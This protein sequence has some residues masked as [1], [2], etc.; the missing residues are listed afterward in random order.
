MALDPEYKHL[1]ARP[2][3]NYRQLFV[4]GRRIRAGVIYRRTINVEHLTPQEVAADF[5][6][7]LIAVLERSGVVSFRELDH[8]TD[9]ID[10]RARQH[11]GDFIV[12]G[13]PDRVEPG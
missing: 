11:R 13:R 5:D 12:A 1:E 3:S 9:L 2:G 7:P 10:L 6:L 8:R 4:K